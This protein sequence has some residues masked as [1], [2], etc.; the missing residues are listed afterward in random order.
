MMG[1]SRSRVHASLT[2]FIQSRLPN[3]CAHR[4]LIFHANAS[5]R[6]ALSHGAPMTAGTV[7]SSHD[8]VRLKAG[9][10]HPLKYLF[11]T[12]CEIVFA[13][14]TPEIIGHMHPDD[15][16][17]VRHVESYML[18]CGTAGHS[19]QKNESSSNLALIMLSLS[20]H[21]DSRC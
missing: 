1:E 19:V 9:C 2:T 17:M 21:C 8:Q 18:A 10:T 13:Y 4:K 14:R 16:F 7:I 11:R 20:S 15:E 12:V 5:C 3:R 6:P